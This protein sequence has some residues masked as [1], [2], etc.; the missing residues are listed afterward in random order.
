[1]PKA[2]SLTSGNRR[3]LGKMPKAFCLTSGIYEVFLERS[4]RKIWVRGEPS[5]EPYIPCYTPQAKRS[6]ARVQRGANDSEQVGRRRA[7]LLCYEIFKSLYSFSITTITV[8]SSWVMTR[9]FINDHFSQFFYRMSFNIANNRFVSRARTCSSV[10]MN[11][12]K[13][14]TSGG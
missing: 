6:V 2:Q 14:Y 7:L 10:S 8:K 4:G 5:P 1:M 12:Q 11:A 3:A 9:K 13:L